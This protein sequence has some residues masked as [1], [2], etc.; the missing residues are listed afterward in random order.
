MNKKL[1]QLEIVGTSLKGTQKPAGKMKFIVI[2]IGVMLLRGI[3]LHRH[4]NSHG[5]KKH[6]TDPQKETDYG[7]ELNEIDELNRIN[8]AVD[9]QTSRCNRGTKIC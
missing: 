3:E 7:V 2:L 9:R 5:H 6:K 1:R 8:K 4:M